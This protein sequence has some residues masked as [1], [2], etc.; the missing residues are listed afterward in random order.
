MSLDREHVLAAFRVLEQAGLA[1]PAILTGKDPEKARAA[2]DSAADTWAAILAD[3]EP[4]DLVAATLAHLREPNPPGQW[5]KAW[6]DTGRILSLVPARRLAAIDDSADAWHETLT[7]LR[8]NAYRNP[9][10]GDLDAADAVRDSAM[11]EGLRAVGGGRGVGQAQT[12]DLVWRAKDFAATYKAGRL[13]GHVI[14]EVAQ[15]AA[16]PTAPRLPGSR[17]SGFARLSGS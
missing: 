15:I 2:I 5:T 8:C 11:R 12:A 7:W 17:G 10:E 16:T 3:L 1:R 9:A 6:P 14:A 13:R 4:E